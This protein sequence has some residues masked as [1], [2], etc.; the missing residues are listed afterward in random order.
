MVK[1]SSEVGTV[2]GG[3]QL[4]PGERCQVRI[5]VTLQHA[6]HTRTHTADYTLI[7]SI[8]QETHTHLTGIIPFLCHLIL[9]IHY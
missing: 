6:A 7:P 2:G 1:H 9:V 4:L 5:Q 3:H 8:H